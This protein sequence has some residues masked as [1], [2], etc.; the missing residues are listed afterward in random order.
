MKL[1]M[2]WMCK[3]AIDF[4]AESFEKVAASKVNVKRT[5]NVIVVCNTTVKSAN[6]I[7]QEK[8]SKNET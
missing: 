4:Q 8:Q 2:Y 3:Q 7:H 6:S 5:S 1:K